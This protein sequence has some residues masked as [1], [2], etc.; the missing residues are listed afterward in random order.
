MLDDDTL[1]ALAAGAYPPTFAE[2][3]ALAAEVLRLQG[4]V[5]AQSAHAGRAE[6]EHAALR[7]R[8]WVTGV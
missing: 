1:R 4:E 8:A 6:A 5:A 2:E 3:R 7:L